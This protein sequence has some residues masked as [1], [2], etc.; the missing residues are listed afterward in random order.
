MKVNLGKIVSE[1]RHFHQK[2]NLCFISSGSTYF[3]KQLQGP[4]QQVLSTPGYGFTLFF[5]DLLFHNRS[6][7]LL[8]GRLQKAYVD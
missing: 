2:T 8:S 4:K 5:M 1:V 6:L 3:S 7:V